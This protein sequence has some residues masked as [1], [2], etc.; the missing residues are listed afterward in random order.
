MVPL[1]VVLLERGV[2]PPPPPPPPVA[3]RT[4]VAVIA[5]PDPIIT[6]PI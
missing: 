3:E 6:P 1:T 4:P 5:R 2:P